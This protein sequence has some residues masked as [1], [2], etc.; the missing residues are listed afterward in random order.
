MEFAQFSLTGAGG[1]LK[2]QSPPNSEPWEVDAEAGDYV[3]SAEF[4]HMD[5]P[6]RTRKVRLAP[7]HF[8]C[9]L[10]KDYP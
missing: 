4:P 5:Y 7:P 9:E 2:P 8:S 10:Y 3:A 6:D 1:R